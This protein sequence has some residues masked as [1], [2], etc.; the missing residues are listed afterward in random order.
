L[1]SSVC[2]TIN[3]IAIQLGKIFDGTCDMWQDELDLICR[4]GRLFGVFTNGGFEEY[5]FGSRKKCL[6]N[7]RE[8]RLGYGY[9]LILSPNML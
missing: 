7:S 6:Q 5:I 3:N 1:Q 9:K 4:N 8:S 2:Y